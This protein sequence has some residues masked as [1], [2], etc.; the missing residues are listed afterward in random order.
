M[1]VEGRKCKREV[2]RRLGVPVADAETVGDCLDP[3]Y[4]QVGGEKL[5]PSILA[6]ANTTGGVV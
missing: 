1:G 6:G 3:P 4:P 2:G 5:S